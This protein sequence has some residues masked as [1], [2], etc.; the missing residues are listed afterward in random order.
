MAARIEM[1]DMPWPWDEE[2]MSAAEMVARAAAAAA[3]Q[4][5]SSKNMS[6]DEA[7]DV[8]LVRSQK[9][10]HERVP[11][12]AF[13][14]GYHLL[15]HMVYDQAVKRPDLI[16][17][18][19]LMRNNT[20]RMKPWHPL[21]QETIFVK[22]DAAAAAAANPEMDHPGYLQYIQNLTSDSVG[23]SGGHFKYIVV[24]GYE[25]STTGRLAHA[26]ATSG[27]VILLATT[28]FRYRFSSRL[29]PWVHYVP[30]SYGSADLIEKLEWL[31]KN[32]DQ[33]QQIARN[34]AA[35]GKSYLRLEDELCYAM[36][37][38]ETVAEAEK[39]SDILLPFDNINNTTAEA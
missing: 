32:D 14:A 4:G 20:D 7:V 6:I 34:A 21:S 38:L 39:D 36:T 26:L 15:R 2:Y 19:L 22:T 9:P 27:A 31:M 13:F 35:F 37:A 3:E 10:W 11:K 5:G 29:L 30:L 12:A 17:A 8:H 25:L 1:G 33:A 24:I 16:V 23:W 28:P 18:P